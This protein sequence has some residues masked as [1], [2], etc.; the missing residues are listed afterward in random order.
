MLFKGL[1]EKC[2]QTGR[3]G[4]QHTRSHLPIHGFTLV[5]L[6]VVI[7]IIALLL[8]ILMPSLSKAREQARRV[9]CLSNLKQLGLAMEMY[10]EDNRELYP[11][12]D[13]NYGGTDAWLRV[14][15]KNYLGN[16]DVSRAWQCQSARVGYWWWYGLEPE[17]DQRLCNPWP[18]WYVNPRSTCSGVA[19]TYGLNAFISPSYYDSGYIKRTEIVS[20]T[21]VFTLVGAHASFTIATKSQIHDGDYF[22]VQ[23][24]EHYTGTTFLFAD[25]HAEFLHDKDIPNSR[26]IDYNFWTGR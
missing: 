25:Q 20:P 1:R 11:P 23:A 9:V 10:L 4:K 6:L 5:E 13:E 12:Y 3:L 21:R 14:L 26:Y 22:G 16:K 8:A 19:A 17:P 15:Q 7:S 24:Y 2:W 18:W